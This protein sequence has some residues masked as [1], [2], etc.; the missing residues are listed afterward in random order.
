MGLLFHLRVTRPICKVFPKISVKDEVSQL[1]RQIETIA[2]ARA[3]INVHDDIGVTIA[4][5]LR[6]C[7]YT[8]SA[9]LREANDDSV[10]LKQPSHVLDGPL[11]QPKKRSS[12]IGC[13][14]DLLLAYCGGV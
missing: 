7:V 9:K 4:A 5:R 2:D 11:L 14:F 10:V 3:V 8:G 13:F 6:K 12:A 1:V